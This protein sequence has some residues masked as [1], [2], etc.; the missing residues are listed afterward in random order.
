MGGVVDTF[1]QTCAS[2]YVCRHVQM[3]HHISVLT[4]TQNLAHIHTH[5]S[6]KI[7]LFIKKKKAMNYYIKTYIH[8]HNK[9]EL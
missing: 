2:T 8:T 6:R 3:Y 1:H 9:I 7:E 4:Y 5:Q